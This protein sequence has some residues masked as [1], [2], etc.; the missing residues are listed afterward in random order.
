VRCRHFGFYALDHGVIT[1]GYYALPQQ[2]CAFQGTPC[3]S[4]VALQ[5]LSHCFTW[6]KQCLTAQ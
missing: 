1:K 2:M 3:A 6:L 4:V 5:I